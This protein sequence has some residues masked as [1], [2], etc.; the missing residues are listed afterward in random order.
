MDKNNY[1]FSNTDI[2]RGTTLPITKNQQNENNAIAS[3]KFTKTRGKTNVTKYLNFVGIRAYYY[4]F[5]SRFKQSVG[6]GLNCY[7]IGTTS[8]HQAETDWI[9]IIDQ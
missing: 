8:S 7:L 5:G 1:L 2:V 3:E 6:L 4:L 9:T